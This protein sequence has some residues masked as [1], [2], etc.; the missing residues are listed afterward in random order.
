MKQ[1]GLG[2]MMFASAMLLV[3]CGSDDDG[4]SAINRAAATQATAS[5]RALHLSPDAPAVNIAVNETVALENVSYR[6]ASGFLTVNAGSTDIDVLVAANGATAI[7]ATVTLTADTKY[8]V[9]AVN[10]VVS[11]EPL[12]LTDTDTPTAG[13]AQLTVVHGAP[14]AP[15]VDIYV[16]APDADFS[17]LSPLLEGVAFKDASDELEVEAGDYRVRVTAAGSSDVIYDSGAF[18]LA[19][20][21]EY[22]VV[23][24]QVSEGLSPIGLTVLT[25]LEGTPVVTIDDARARVRVVHAS[26]DAPAVDV[27]VDDAEVLADV[28]FK[29]ASDYL[30]LLGDT[31]SVEVLQANSASAVISAD[32]TLDP[33]TDYTVIA[34]NSVANIEALVLADDNTAPADGAVKVRLV[35]G[36]QQAGTVDIYIVEPGADISDAEPTV[37]GFEFKD[38]TGYLEV[39]ADD[40][41]VLIT[42][43]NT[44]QVAI[45]TGTLSLAAGVVRTAIAVDPEAS[46]ADFGVVLLQD[47]N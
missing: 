5:L 36:A 25:D 20:G 18:S 43:G 26:A 23:A 21:V 15:A 4:S 42:V 28:T 33:R 14:A 34:L 32:L 13:F 29:D 7:D 44:K 8:T 45:D 12:V 35:H 9:I 41:Q 22:I 38:D 46:E 24:S 47:L 19:D 11:I 30:E 31:Y 27:T 3:G 39:P 17:D 40:Y 16:S 1:L 6:Q 37:S 10:E 2:S